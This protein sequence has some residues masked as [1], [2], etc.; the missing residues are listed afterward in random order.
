[1]NQRGKCLRRLALKKIVIGQLFASL[2]LTLASA[3]LTEAAT[4]RVPQDATTIQQGINVAAS[5]DT[6]LVAPGTYFENINFVGKA[7]TVQSEQGPQ[8]T[9]ID[10][11]NTFGPIVTFQSGE[12]QVSRLS[13]F[14]LQNGRASFG[15]GIFIQ[16]AS[17]TVDG[18]IITH[19]EADAGAGV[20]MT[21]SAAVIQNNQI[22]ENRANSSTDGG[23]GMLIHN[24]TA[25]RISGNSILNNSVAAI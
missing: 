6:V 11:H 12:T 17:P 16:S 2:A 4:I 5:G 8:V 23:G 9:I 21:A 18:N 20:L 22:I 14:R 7:I 19:N 13:G 1:M 3:A 25:A 15:A 24:T 10:G